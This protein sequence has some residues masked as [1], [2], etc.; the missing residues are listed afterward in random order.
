MFVTKTDNSKH[1]YVTR[2]LMDGKPRFVAVDEWI[3]GSGSW[4]SFSKVA[5]DHDFWGIILEKAWAKIH[6]SYMITQGGWHTAVW[7]A[8][9]SAPT[10]NQMHS[11]ISVDALFALL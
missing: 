11:S 9:T 1:V 3:P 10:F 6:G 8:M 5:G 4:P 2:W 7:A